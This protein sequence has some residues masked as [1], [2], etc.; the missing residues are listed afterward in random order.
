MNYLRR[1]E[2]NGYIGGVCAGVSDYTKTDV[3]IWRFLFLFGSILTTLPFV[4][5]YI[6]LWI[7]M[8]S[9]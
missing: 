9:K 8:P 6:I 1:N 7:I 2:K 5:I 4:L 3:V